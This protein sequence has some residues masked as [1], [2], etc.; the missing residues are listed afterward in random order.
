MSTETPIDPEEAKR[1]S[2]G[3]SM[4]MSREAVTRRLEICAEL[5][6]LSRE[7]GRAR[8]APPAAGTDDYQRRQS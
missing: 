1:L 5:S 6:E 8:H 3:I 7:L 2:R 4:D